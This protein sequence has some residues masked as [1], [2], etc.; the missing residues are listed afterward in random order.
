M[1]DTIIGVGQNCES[2][3]C[4]SLRFLDFV[5]LSGHLSPLLFTRLCQVVYHFTIYQCLSLTTLEDLKH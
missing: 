3:L 5:S 2:F 4:P 1:S